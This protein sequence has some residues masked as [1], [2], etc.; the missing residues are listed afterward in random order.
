M[1]PRDLAVHP[2]K[3]KV[4][5]LNWLR[6]RVG[7]YPGVRLD[8][9]LKAFNMERCPAYKDGGW[10]MEL[11]TKVCMCGRVVVRGA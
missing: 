10:L 1:L 8:I 3:A 2:F 6:Y 11:V 5:C 7:A 4:L 9:P